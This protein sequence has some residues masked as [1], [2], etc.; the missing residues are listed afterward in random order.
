MKAQK[1]RSRLREATAAAILDAAEEVFAERGLSAAHMNDIA[2]RAGV[3]VGTLYNHFTDRDALLKA[4]IEQRRAGLYEVMDRFLAQ[5]PSGDFRADLK[6]LVQCIWGYF[7]QHQRFHQIMHRLEYGLNDQ[8]YP[9]TAACAPHMKRE[10]YVRLEKL[11]KRGL[12]QKALRAELATYYP[13]LL[14]GIL[15]SIKMQQTES[16]HEAPMPLDEV[17]RFFMEGAGA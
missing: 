17:V 5:P 4:L 16:G 11:I 7:E 15:R 3:A 6:G 1:L 8:I 10:M 2:G 12:K 9:Q 13:W 14:I